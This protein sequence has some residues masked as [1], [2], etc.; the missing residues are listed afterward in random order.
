M[1]ISNTAKVLGS[2]DATNISSEAAIAEYLMHNLQGYHYQ[3]RN[4]HNNDK[5]IIETVLQAYAKLI[6]DAGVKII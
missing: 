4:V 2:L 1:D 6:Q 3:K 5:L